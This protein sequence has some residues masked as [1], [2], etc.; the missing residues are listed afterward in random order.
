[1]MDVVNYVVCIMALIA[2]CAE[3]WLIVKRNRTIVVKGKDD[4]FSFC[5]IMMFA[6]LFLRPNEAAGLTESLRNTL[7]L[8][9][10]F[11][12]MAVKRGVSTRGI[13]KLG[14]VIPWERLQEIQIEPYQ[15]SKVAVYFQTEKGRFK[16][17]YPRHQL[18]KLIYELQKYFPKIML[19]ESLNLK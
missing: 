10:L 8:M 12:S 16:L 9:A 1:M 19:E 5:L 3:A 15:M 6:M 17:L 2:L 18:K 7:V 14:F 4:F 11:F 13:E